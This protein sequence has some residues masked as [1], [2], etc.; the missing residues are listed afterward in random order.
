MATATAGKQQKY[1]LTTH[2]VVDFQQEN[3]SIVLHGRTG[4]DYIQTIDSSLSLAVNKHHICK[5]LGGT[6]KQMVVQALEA[7]IHNHP[8]S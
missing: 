5:T 7:H 8:I 3:E 1:I 6:R 2:K 4:I